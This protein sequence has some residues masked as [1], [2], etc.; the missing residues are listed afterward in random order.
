M[1]LV[2]EDGRGMTMHCCSGGEA[3]LN[4]FANGRAKGLACCDGHRAQEVTQTYRFDFSN[5]AVTWFVFLDE[6]SGGPRR[7]VTL[8][9]S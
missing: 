9:S 4:V 2:G 7:L 3:K 6:G 5:P 8:G 1:V